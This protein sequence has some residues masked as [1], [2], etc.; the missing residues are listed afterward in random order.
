MNIKIQYFN[1]LLELLGA[2]KTLVPLSK[3]RTI[4]AG[5]DKFNPLRGSQEVGTVKRLQQQSQ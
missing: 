5:Y 2:N 4:F 1:A 3:D